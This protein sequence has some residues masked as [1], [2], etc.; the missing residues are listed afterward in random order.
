MTRTQ[1]NDKIIVTAKLKYPGEL[2]ATTIFFAFVFVLILKQILLDSKI[3]MEW[4][5]LLLGCLTAFISIV[6]IGRH[7]YKKLVI[8]PDKII[9]RP[10]F[11]YQ[12]MTI[13]LDN[14]KGFELFETVIIGGLGYNIQLITT[15]G[16]KIVFPQDNYKNYEKII[17]G[18]HKSNLPYL[19]Q[20]EMQSNYKTTYSK[21]LKWSAILLPFIYGLFLLLKVIKR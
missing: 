12:P 14:L 16:K 9:I 8:Y 13:Q 2:Y 10:I 5:L 4:W 7:Q 18:F 17:A 3:Q 6:L 15:T 1:D 11:S 19:G 21:L 20:K